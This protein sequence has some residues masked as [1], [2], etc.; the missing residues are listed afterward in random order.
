AIVWGVWG[1]DPKLAYALVNAV[2]VLIIACPCAL[3]L[4]T[5]MSIMVATGRGASVGVLFKNAEAIEMLRKVDTL[6]VD[7]TGTLTVGKPKLVSVKSFGISEGEILSLAASLEQL[8]E[9]PLAH[10][11]VVGAKE[12]GL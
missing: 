9:H 4:A 7:K 8:S 10:A 3:G 12:K 5:P 6:V 11:I 2:A 1:P